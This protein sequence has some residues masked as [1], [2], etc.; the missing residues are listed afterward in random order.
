MNEIVEQIRKTP[1]LQR[2]EMAQRMIGTM[3]REGRPPSMSVP[4]LATD[5]DLFI[6][7]TIDDAADVIRAI[8]AIQLKG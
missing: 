6:S 2:L 5:E 1:L 8:Q 4:A 3:C 7:T